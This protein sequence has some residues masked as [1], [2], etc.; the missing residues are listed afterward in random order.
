M[1]AI[2]PMLV[3]VPGAAAPTDAPA[4][5]GGEGGLQLAIAFKQEPFPQATVLT[6]GSRRFLAVT[7]YANGPLEYALYAYEA[8]TEQTHRLLLLEGEAEA[9]F[10]DRQAPGRGRAGAGAGA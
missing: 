4:P 10:A 5:G 1:A 8:A 3:L 9:L 7:A 6:A 2:L